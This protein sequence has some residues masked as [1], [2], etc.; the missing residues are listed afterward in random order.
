LG[1]R[2]W[3]HQDYTGID[4]TQYVIGETVNAK[5]L[6]VSGAGM[7]D[8]S[9]AATLS[10]PV[11]QRQARPYPPG[12]L[13]VLGNRYPSAV[14]G[15]LV[16]AWAH[17]SR[18]LQADQLVDTQ[19]ANVG[20]EPGTTYTVRV[21]VNNVLDSTTTGVTVTTF[22]PLVSADGLVRVE[23]DAVRD[24]LASWQ[25]LDASFTYTRGQTRLTED[26]DIRITEAGDTRI[27]ES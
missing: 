11:K 12:K 9:L 6:T 22:T 5:L 25:S 26:G 8:P 13:T 7:L 18:L 3:F 27:T 19:Q 2:L 1:A 16:L 24:G 10:L 15:A 20:P 21:Y 14:E 4:S 23:I 17:R